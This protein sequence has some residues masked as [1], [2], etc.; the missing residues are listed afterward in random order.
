MNTIFRA[1]GSLK[2]PSGIL[3]GLQ[4]RETPLDSLQRWHAVTNCT[5]RVLE[6]YSAIDV[7][8]RIMC[9]GPT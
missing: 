6:A 9:V 2:F 4:T 5:V 8:Y 7:D 3:R 1:M